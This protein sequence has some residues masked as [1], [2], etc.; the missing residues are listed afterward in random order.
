VSEE[1]QKTAIRGLNQAFEKKD[2]DRVL[3]FYAEDAT[4]VVPEGTFDGKGQIRQWWGWQIQQLSQGTSEE[5]DMMAEG[6]EIAAAHV[7]GATLTNGAKWKTPIACFYKF[8]GPKI[9]R[10]RMYYD[11]LSIAQQAA[12]GEAKGIIGSVTAQ[13]EKGLR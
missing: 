5:I 7:I 8:T 11:R 3:S 13:M 9:Q 1:D 2:L 10:H 4:L 12:T 6:D